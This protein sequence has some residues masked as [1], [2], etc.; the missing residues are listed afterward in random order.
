MCGKL[1]FN[2]GGVQMKIKT[3][4]VLAITVSLIFISANLI[5]SQEA[6]NNPDTQWVW[7]EVSI[8]DTQNK[9]IL[10][11]YFDYETDQEKEININIDDKTTYENIKSMNEL[12]PKD[13]VSIDYIVSADGKNIAK[14]ISIEKPENTQNVQ[15]GNTTEQ[16][17]PS[18]SEESK[19]MGY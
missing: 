16:K 19:T 11:K 8:L 2:L 6:Q 17:T 3:G 15:E 10:V 1:F 12:K 14:N 5:F 4:L 9:A 18:Q 7:G 13:T